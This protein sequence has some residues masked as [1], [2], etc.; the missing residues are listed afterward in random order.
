L[1][2]FERL[3]KLK[4]D[5]GQER[6]REIKE[7]DK[8]TVYFFAK[9]NQRRRKKLISCL[10]DGVITK[11]KELMQHVVQFYKKLFCKKPRE[12][13]SLDE[14]FWAEEEKVTSEENDLLEREFSEEEVKM[15]IDESY[16]EGAS[17]L[18]GLSFLFY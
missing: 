5:R 1:N 15:A 6:E 3:K 7:G 14:D 16:A 11:D 9:A 12:N 13:M 10:K 17:G 2:K 18:N 8:N 4:K